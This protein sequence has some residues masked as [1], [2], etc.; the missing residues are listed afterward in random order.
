LTRTDS[1]VVGVLV[2]LFAILAGMVS[3]PG[4]TPAAPSTAPLDE[5]PEPFV[6]RPYRE[7]VLG[8]P[9]SISPLTARTQADR[10]LVALLFSGLVRN[11]PSGT[12]LPDLAESWTVD[13]TGATWTFQLRED[14]AWHDG[15]PVTA[16][17]VVFTIQ[18]LQDPEY[19]G[20]AA[21]SWNDAT[22]EATGPRTVTFTLANPLGGFLQAAT[23]PI[24]PAHLLTDV[25]V[26]A[27]ADDAFGQ[28]P[29]GTG[30]FALIRFDGE[31]AEL[32]PAATVMPHETQAPAPEPSASMVD[33]LAT[34][35][36]TAR[37]TEAS[38]YLSGIEFQYFDDAASLAAAYR[39]GGL[40]AASGLSPEVAGELAATPG[41]RMLRYPGSTLTAVLFNLR[42]NRH[43]FTTPAI[44]TAFL[45]AIDRPALIEAAFARVAGAANGPIPPTSPFF[46]AKA[47]DPVGFSR[48]SAQK[49]LTAAGWKKSENAW[50]RATDTKPITFELLSPDAESNP[51]LFAAAAAVAADWKYIGVQVTHVPLPP[52]EFVSERLATA[53]FTAAV[54]DVTIGLDPDLYPLMA[55]SQTLTGGSNIIGLQDPEL[56][57]LLLAARKPAPMADRN[58]AYAALQVHLAKG[59]YLL[60]LAFADEPIVVRDT[61]QGPRIRQVADRSDRFW[62]VLTWRLAADR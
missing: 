29:V 14:A 58:A 8:R 60:P 51:G 50:R 17:D 49:A 32:A 56:D 37:P 40:D 62:D 20:P 26:S 31:I 57:R 5:T 61:V 6:T 33:S 24:A 46:D 54:A 11:G 42:A 27:L 59:M 13:E 4:L 48:D 3:A 44:R 38:P 21:G 55:S 34:P 45:S 30:A 52:A 41:S 47:A 1:F 15:E 10:D 2:V 25:P 28:Q 12:L 43:V 23:Q 53:D 19:A 22:V 36:P 39:A 35:A 18:T 9:F 7:G 16:D